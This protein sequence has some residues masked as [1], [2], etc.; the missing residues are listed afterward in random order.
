MENRYEIKAQEVLGKPFLDINPNWRREG[1]AEPMERLLRGEVEE[2]ALEGVEHETIKKGRVILNVKGSLLRENLAPSGA[3][4]LIE[5]ITRRLPA[6]VWLSSFAGQVKPPLAAPPA[7]AT[8]PAAD[9]AA[10]A[11]P[12]VQ[13]A[14]GVGT[15]SFSASA[16]DYLSVAAWLDALAEDP[17]VA[18]VN[19]GSLSRAASDG[20]SVVNF[21]STAKITQEAGSDRAERLL[22]DDSAQ[23]P[24]GQKPAG[25][26]P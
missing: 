26:T 23:V 8:D 14:A 4:L 12:V 13:P 9:P 22:P 10:A 17:A 7:G 18:A 25:V 1:L 2:F 5:D 3:V 24:G 6:G 11:A 20:Q 19:V 21:S 16:L 15:L